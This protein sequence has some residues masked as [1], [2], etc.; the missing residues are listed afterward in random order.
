MAQPIEDVLRVWRELERVHEALPDDAPERRLVRIE[1]FQA[2]RLYQS[3]TRRQT[4]THAVLADAQDAIPRAEDM[5]ARASARLAGRDHG[6]A[7]RR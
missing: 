3:M 5:L 2:K 4:E 7:R 6:K 1:I